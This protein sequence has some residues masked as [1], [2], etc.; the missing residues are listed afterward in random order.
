VIRFEGWHF[1]L[2]AKHSEKLRAIAKKILVQALG[3][4]EKGSP[5]S[6]KDIQGKPRA[7]L[8]IWR[9][10]K[11]PRLLCSLESFAET[12]SG[13]DVTLPGWK[14]VPLGGKRKLVKQFEECMRQIVHDIPALVDALDNLDDDAK[15]QAAYA[16][17]KH[18]RRAKAAI[19][20]LSKALRAHDV[21]LR[22]WVAEALLKIDP[23][24]RAAAATVSNELRN[25]NKEI[26]QSAAD[27][28]RTF[29]AGKETHKK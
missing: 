1:Q 7:V 29:I 24:N 6:Q 28:Y 20:A 16:L 9:E 8:E 19:P 17:G 22:L 5:G 27:L 25:P 2:T 21:S 12:P 26:Q 18:G 3:W 13:I 10:G 14:T 4:L 15:G 23:S 11:P